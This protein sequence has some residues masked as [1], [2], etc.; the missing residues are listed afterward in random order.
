MANEVF[1][2]NRNFSKDLIGDLLLE[3]IQIGKGKSRF[4]VCQRLMGADGQL[5][6]VYSCY[7]HYRL[8]GCRDID[9]AA[10]VG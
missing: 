3:S 9:K 4:A 6:S 5:V 10:T 8:A 1:Y 2:Y 7:R